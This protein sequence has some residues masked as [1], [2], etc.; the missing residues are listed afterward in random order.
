MQEIKA[1]KRYAQ[2]IL[3][4]GIVLVVWRCDRLNTADQIKR[5]VLDE[6][7]GY[8]K[9]QQVNGIDF[10]VLLSP[11]E[12]ESIRRLERKEHW[13][14][15]D[16]DSVYSSV[17]D[18][19]LFYFQMGTEQGQNLLQNSST[20]NEDY[21]TKLQHLIGSIKD[22]FYLVSEGDTVSCALHHFE[23]GYGLSPNMNITLVFPK[24]ESA[25]QSATL[26]YNDRLFETGVVKFPFTRETL[27]KAF[28]LTNYSN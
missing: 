2:L 22:D 18:H 24:E 25:G 19:R 6:T 12:F 10:R 1:L 4:G 7:H 17:K 9:K 14:K 3:L 28:E 26:I 20:T 27:E 15:T 8:I 5:F 16:F 23:R 11:P 13:N 21:N